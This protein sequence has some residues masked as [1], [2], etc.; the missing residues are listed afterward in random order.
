MAAQATP[1]RSAS[2]A[3][4][5]RAPVVVASASGTGSAVRWLVAA[6]LLA[7][8][9]LVVLYGL[10]A[11]WKWG[12]V[13]EAGLDPLDVLPLVPR[14]QLVTLGTELV[15]LTLIALP[16]TF[17]LVLALHLALPDEGRAWGVPFGLARLTA[18]QVR[19]RRDLDE[20]RADVG[21]DELVGRRIKRLNTRAHRVRA[22]IE[23]RTWL[24]RIV[25]LAGA[26]TAILLSSP[27]R[28]AVAAFGLWTIRRVGGGTARVALVVFT[29]LL[30]AV[31]VERFA[32]PEPLPDAS[33]RTTNGA[34]VK[35]P[36]LTQ[37]RD[38]WFLVVDDRRLKAIP[39]TSVAKSS[40]AF[41]PGRDEGTLGARPLDALR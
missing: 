11:L 15:L 7:I 29:T 27:A 33:V 16:I 37:T 10:G 38:T 18:E 19:L 35:A 23:Q 34:L 20:L 2:P 36:L 1:L 26:A 40:V 22:R 30:L 6:P 39:T 9:G 4:A 12:Q 25:L 5:Q 3:V 14:D 8:G 32:A 31:T 17:G 21:A 41:A 28:L 24:L 13:R